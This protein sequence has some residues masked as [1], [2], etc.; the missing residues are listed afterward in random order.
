M[1]GE[2]MDPMTKKMKKVRETWTMVDN[3]TQKME[4]FE[5]APDGK[6][7]KSMEIVMRRKK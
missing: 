7:Y 5:T 4:M 2:S 3:D 6:E 1:S